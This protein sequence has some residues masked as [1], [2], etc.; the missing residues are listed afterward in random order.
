MVKTRSG[1]YG[2]RHCR[3]CK[4]LNDA[5]RDRFQRHVG[6]M[7]RLL[8]DGLSATSAGF[9]EWQQRVWMFFEDVETRQPKMRR[10]SV[11]SDA[12]VS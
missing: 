2:N 1:N 10:T 3:E 6:Q 12:E 11:A 9:R 5:K 4:R 8:R 7:E